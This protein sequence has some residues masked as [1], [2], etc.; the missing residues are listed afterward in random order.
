MYNIL[1][2]IPFTFFRRFLLEIVQE[3][4][5]EAVR[6]QGGRL[7]KR[8]EK[9][10]KKLWR[11]CSSASIILSRVWGRDGARMVTFLHGKGKG[12][13]SATLVANS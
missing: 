2:F 11:Q 8:K 6:P 13:G 4:R 10:E 9:R 7:K 3:N 12:D 1:T 5:T